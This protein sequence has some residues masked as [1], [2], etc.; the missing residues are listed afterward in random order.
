MNKEGQDLGGKTET[1]IV[2]TGR[3]RRGP[4]ATGLCLCF[5]GR[6]TWLWGAR[7]SAPSD[8]RVRES[9]S[10]ATSGRIKWADDCETHHTK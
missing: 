9:V 7:E 5:S 1:G 3:G 6:G 2:T 4:G 8:G 10:T